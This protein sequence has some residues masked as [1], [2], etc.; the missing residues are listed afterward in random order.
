MSTQTHCETCLRPTLGAPCTRHPHAE[1]LDARWDGDWIAILRGQKKTRRMKLLILSMVPLLVL[2]VAIFPISLHGSILSMQLMNMCA[3][4]P[5][6][7]RE[8]HD[9]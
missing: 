4:H 3:R 9:K 6:A 2:P 1:L 5:H 7:E 8:A